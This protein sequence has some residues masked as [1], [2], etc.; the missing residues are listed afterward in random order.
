MLSI[1]Y[2][3]LYKIEKRRLCI[4]TLNNLRATVVLSDEDPTHS[5]AISNQKTSM[6][7]T[8]GGDADY[9]VARLD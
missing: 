8:K 6:E 4:G 9:H 7:E 3:N 1:V 2:G 5:G